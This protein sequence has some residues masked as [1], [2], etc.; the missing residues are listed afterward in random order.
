MGNGDKRAGL[1]GALCQLR[2]GLG[3]IAE[4]LLATGG[5]RKIERQANGQDVPQPTKLRLRRVQ[6][7]ADN[8]REVIGAKGARV[9]NLK[10]E[11]RHKVLGEREKVVARLAVEP[12]NFFGRL[13]AVRNGGVGVEVAFPEAARL[14]EGKSVHGF[15]FG[16][17]STN[18]IIS[19][20]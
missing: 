18:S 16:F 12:T 14:V 13:L 15:P 20:Q 19:V 10:V 8:R 9:G 1:H 17:I 7:R 6:L 2:A 5:R 11:L 4:I 3:A